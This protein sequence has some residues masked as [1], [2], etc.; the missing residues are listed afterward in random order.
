MSAAFKKKDSTKKASKKRIETEQM[1]LQKQKQCEQNDNIDKDNFFCKYNPNEEYGMEFITLSDGS[2]KPCCIPKTNPM[3]IKSERERLL[4]QLFQMENRIQL[5]SGLLDEYFTKTTEFLMSVQEQQRFN[6]LVTELSTITQA[7]QSKI[8]ICMQTNIYDESYLGLTNLPEIICE[9]LHDA[10]KTLQHAFFPRLFFVEKK[11]ADA[12]AKKKANQG[13]Y[14]NYFT[15][16]L[17]KLKGLLSGVRSAVRVTFNFLYTYGFS[18]FKRFLSVARDKVQDIVDF[19]CNIKD[20]DQ[21]QNFYLYL[22]Q[23]LTTHLTQ[24]QYMILNNAFKRFCDPQEYKLLKYVI[25]SSPFLKKASSSN[26]ENGGDVSFLYLQKITSEL[27]ENTKEE[28]LNVCTILGN[29]RKKLCAEILWAICVY[30]LELLRGIFTYSR[31]F[32]CGG[33]GQNTNRIQEQKTEEEEE[34]SK[35]QQGGEGERKAQWKPLENNELSLQLEGLSLSY[36]ESLLDPDDPMKQYAPLRTSNEQQQFSADEGKVIFTI[37]NAIYLQQSMN[38]V[39]SV[40]IFFWVF[41]KANFVPKDDIESDL[42]DFNIDDETK[43]ADVKEINGQLDKINK[44]VNKDSRRQFC[45]A[46]GN[47]PEVCDTLVESHEAITALPNIVGRHKAYVAKTK[48]IEDNKKM[49]NTEKSFL[50][51]PEAIDSFLSDIVDVRPT[52]PT[53]FQQELKAK[54]AQIKN[55]YNADLKAYLERKKQQEAMKTTTQQ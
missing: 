3:E 6:V 51:S 17:T 36:I 42:D 41:T 4:Q 53:P 22:Y 50:R 30:S 35:E 55:K 19:S 32:T 27:H 45:L 54:I 20:E 1:K 14:W 48:A 15:K 7:V 47:K 25:N 11:L 16:I 2:V 12:R 18:N 5:A 13:S 26:P 8:Q 34:Q 46:N 9:P 40:Y 21:I 23:Q 44:P 43:L 28:F 37:N 10:V 31:P 33:S 52:V 49:E 38:L 29:I 39:N 24:R